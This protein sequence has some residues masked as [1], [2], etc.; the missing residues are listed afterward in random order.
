MRR[1]NRVGVDTVKVKFA[2]S[3]LGPCYRTQVFPNHPEG[4]V[5]RKRKIKREKSLSRIKGREL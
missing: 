1:R 5:I 4:N 3:F 2:F